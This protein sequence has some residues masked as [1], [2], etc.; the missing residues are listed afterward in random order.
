[1][2]F[3]R[4]VVFPIFIFFL[5]ACSGNTS[6]LAEKYKVDEADVEECSDLFSTEDIELALQAI[7]KNKT[8]FGGLKTNC[9][10]LHIELS[11]KIFNIEYLSSRASGMSPVAAENEYQSSYED[12]LSS[13]ARSLG[14]KKNIA[15]SYIRK[16]GQREGDEV[17][18]TISTLSPP[19]SIVS[20]AL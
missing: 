14:V 15:E 18:D 16:H 9:S 7:S 10:D 2:S 8:L 12:N 6:E 4:L 13:Y 11:D 5:A 1:M 19:K 20:D 3:P 17:I